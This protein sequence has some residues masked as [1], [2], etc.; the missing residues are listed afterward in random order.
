MKATPL[1]AGAVITAAVL[2]T[3]RSSARR[4][5]QQGA[6]IVSQDAE[7]E[8]P[9]L[10]VFSTEAEAAAHAEAVAGDWPDG[11]VTYAHDP[12]AS[13]RGGSRIAG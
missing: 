8:N 5:D 9:L 1:L 13:P 11:T 12:Q 7:P 10:G 4:T 3:A 6:W 2:V